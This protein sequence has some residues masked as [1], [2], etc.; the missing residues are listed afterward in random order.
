MA[1]PDGIARDTESVPSR[2]SPGKGVS[3]RSAGC[4]L[5]VDSR[6]RSY[7]WILRVPLCRLLLRGVSDVSDKMSP[8]SELDLGRVLCPAPAACSQ[9]SQ[10]PQYAVSRW[11]FENSVLLLELL[12]FA[13]LK[14]RFRRDHARFDCEKRCKQIAE[15][16]PTFRLSVPGAIGTRAS[17]WQ[18]FIVSFWSPSYSLPTRR[19]TRDGGVISSRD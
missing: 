10:H 17:S 4:L 12:F 2:L 19:P 6:E 5:V 13:R 3:E 11:K 18:R 7:P 9:A 15:A 14:S 1:R 8:R 16:T